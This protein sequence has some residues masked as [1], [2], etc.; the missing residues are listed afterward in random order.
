MAN[1]RPDRVYRTGVVEAFDRRNGFERGLHNDLNV[2]VG[3]TAPM[4]L[5]RRDGSCAC[6]AA[7][8]APAAP[9]LGL[10]YIEA[11]KS[12]TLGGLV[13][14]QPSPGLLLPTPQIP[15]RPQ[16]S[17]RGTLLNKLK[18]SSD[19]QP[20]PPVAPRFPTNLPQP[21]QMPTAGTRGVV[22]PAQG[23]SWRR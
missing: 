17:W 11:T 16:L 19:E 10:P 6:P 13:Y 1:L 21:I 20:Q 5:R 18:L 4:R 12:F 15:P 3:A 9:P 7:P 22:T 14:R 2:I 8:A 23:T